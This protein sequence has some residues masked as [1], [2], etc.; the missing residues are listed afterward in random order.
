MLESHLCQHLWP[1]K[2]PAYHIRTEITSQIV[3]HAKAASYTGQD[4]THCC[5]PVVTLSDTIAG[6]QYSSKD[7]LGPL[8][9]SLIPPREK[10][11]LD[12]RFATKFALHWGTIVSA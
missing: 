4:A 8:A 12:Y 6:P 7:T 5:I 11:T 1:Y 2:Q 3:V 9:E 10:H